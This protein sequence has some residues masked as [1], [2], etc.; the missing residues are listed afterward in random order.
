M[1]KHL[2]LMRQEGD[3]DAV[4]DDVYPVLDRR[5]DSLDP[6]RDPPPVRPADHRHGPL[7]RPLADLVAMA[8]TPPG[9]SQDQPLPPPRPPRTSAS[10]YMTIPAGVLSWLLWML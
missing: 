5:A 2:G 4:R 3:A 7:R 8:T 9:T 6:Q 1:S 10:I